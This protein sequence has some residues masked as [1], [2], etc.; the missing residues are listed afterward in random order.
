MERRYGVL[1]LIGVVYKI[2]AILVAA[3]TVGAVV[4]ILLSVVLGPGALDLP[5]MWSRR[6]PMGRTMG[7]AFGAVMA[8][9][10]G[11]GLAL[12]LF[13]IGQ[14]IDLFI[15]MEANTRATTALLAD[16]LAARRAP[17]PSPE[18][19]AAPPPGTGYQPDVD[20]AP[21]PSAR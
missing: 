4:L 1:R 12:T 7:N 5:L 3:L 2:S 13:G 14:G 8:L 6:M 19:P 17:R 10:Y 11:A 20:D 18:A 21:A 9:L 16:L 15:S